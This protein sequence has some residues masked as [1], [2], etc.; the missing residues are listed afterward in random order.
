MPN[1]PC[2]WFYSNSPKCLQ[3]VFTVNKAAK[4]TVCMLRLLCFKIRSC[5]APNGIPTGS[6]YEI[7]R[8]QVQYQLWKTECRNTSSI[9]GNEN[10]IE[11]WKSLILRLSRR[12]YFQFGSIFSQAH[13]AKFDQFSCACKLHLLCSRDK[14]LPRA[15]SVCLSLCQWLGRKADPDPKESVQLRG[16]RYINKQVNPMGREL[17]KYLEDTFGIGGT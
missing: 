12:T 7:S 4:V 5:D 14:H 16:G 6:V 13:S 17:E 10:K 11:S 9:L 15:Y 8:L 2:S 1:Y 3:K